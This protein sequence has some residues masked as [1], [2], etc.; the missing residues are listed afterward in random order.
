MPGGRWTT[1]TMPWQLVDYISISSWPWTTDDASCKGH[2]WGLLD[3]R[4]LLVL[5]LILVEKKAGVP[6]N[7]FSVGWTALPTVQPVQEGQE[8]KAGKRAKAQS[9]TIKKGSP[10]YL[11]WGMPVVNNPPPMYIDPQVANVEY[12]LEASSA[13]LKIHHLLPE[14]FLVTY[15]DVIPGECPW[16]SPTGPTTD[17]CGVLPQGRA[18]PCERLLR[19]LS[20]RGAERACGSAQRTRG[21]EGVWQCSADAGRRVRVAVLSGR[22]AER[23]C[24][25]AQH[26]RGGEGVW[27]CSADAG[28]FLQGG[29][30]GVWQCSA[31]AGRFLQGNFTQIPNTV[32]SG[33]GAERACGSGQRTRGGEGVW[34]WS[35]TISMVC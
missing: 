26:T 11:M 2:L 12:M 35:A 25:S 7:E 17:S 4:C 15:S 28:R 18:L 30:E 29:G 14:N 1:L 27:Q 34:Q 3:T 33:R 23:A 10:R 21:G 31:D 22:G 16:R 19:V 32:V 5:D 9:S 20:G 8:G 24:G 6:I 13:F